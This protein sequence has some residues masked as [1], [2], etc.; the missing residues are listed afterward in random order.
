[1]ASRA[2][3][4]TDAVLY[5]I[6]DEYRTAREISRKTGMSERA[7]RRAL[8]ALVEQGAVERATARDGRRRLTVRYGRKKGD[9]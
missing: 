1:M 2:V 6:W 5:V 7:A 4:E 9:G 3:S 8:R